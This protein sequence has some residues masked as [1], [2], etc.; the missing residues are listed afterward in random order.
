MK[1][2]R[3]AAASILLALLLILEICD[4]LY[5][6]RQERLCRLPVLMYHHFDETSSCYTVVSV[7]RFREQ[8]HIFDE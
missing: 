1:W 4:I 5:I 2:K 3:R 6:T 8:T 7:S